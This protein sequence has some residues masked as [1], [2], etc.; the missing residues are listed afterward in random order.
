MVEEP[1]QRPPNHWR[2]YRITHP[3]KRAFL[4]EYS[5][6][7]SITWSADKAEIARRTHYDWLDADPDYVQAFADAQ[8]RYCE[9]LE[10]EADRRAVDGTEKP[11]FYQGVVAG[12]VR[13]YSDTLLMF[14]LKALAPDKYKDRSQQENTGTVKHEHRH[15]LDASNLTPEELTSLGSLVRKLADS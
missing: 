3:R 15:Q 5:L 14:R 12:Y 4:S 8:E 6:T 1:G 7:G 10:S 9:K 13:E 11:V 2:A